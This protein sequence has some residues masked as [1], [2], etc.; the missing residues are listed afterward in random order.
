MLPPKQVAGRTAAWVSTTPGPLREGG[1]LVPVIHPDAKCV[2]HI[3]YGDGAE[4]CQR[5]PGSKRRKLAAT[6]LNKWDDFY[7]LMG[8]VLTPSRVTVFIP[9]GSK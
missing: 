2:A 7:L 3:T 8:C 9:T 4:S 1:Y 5:V 6:E